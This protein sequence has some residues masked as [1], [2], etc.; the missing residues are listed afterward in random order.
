MTCPRY[1]DGRDVSAKNDVKMI[2]NATS[3]VPKVQEFDRQNRQPQLKVQVFDSWLEE[4]GVKVLI[5]DR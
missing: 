2:T 1:S 5:L 3:S 4:N